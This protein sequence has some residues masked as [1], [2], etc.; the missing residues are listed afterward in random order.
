M[1]RSLLTVLIFGSLSFSCQDDD[2]AVFHLE[3]GTY[4]GTFYRSS[5]NARWATAHVSLTIEGGRFS[6][7]S[8]TPHYPALCEGSVVPVGA[9]A[10]RFSNDCA[11]TADFDWSFILD[12][13]YQ[14]QSAD[15]GLVFYREYE[16]SVYD[17]Y[18]LSREE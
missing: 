16:G 4:T 17:T 14:I 18:A 6:G 9:D 7:S 10:L 1:K 13:T 5:P 15:T 12:G 3:E 11:W 2:P 8:D